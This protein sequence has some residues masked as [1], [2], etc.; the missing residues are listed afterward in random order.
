MTGLSLAGVT[1]LVS[2][3]IV[4]GA[5]C[6]SSSGDNGSQTSC[7]QGTR[8]VGQ[9]CVVAFDASATG[10]GSVDGAP[11]SDG[12]PDANADASG[13]AF[14]GVAAV[15]PASTTS[16]FAA[17][18][19]VQNPGTPAYA[20]RYLVFASPAGT[21]IDYTK[22]LA[23]TAPGATS[24]TISKLGAGTVSVAVRALDAAGRSDRNTVV[25]S[26]S[27]AADTTAP[28]FAGATS[29]APAGA[30]AVT[31]AWKAA[32]D[33]LTP[34]AALVYDVYV[35]DPSGEYDFAL[36]ALTTA[37]GVTSATVT[38]LYDPTE[39]YRFIVRARDA[40]GNIDTNTATVTSTAGVDTTPPVFAGCRSAIADSAGSAIVTWNLAVD[41][42]TPQSLIAYDVY[43][44][45]TEGT[46]DFTKP[47]STVT[48]LGAA[49][50][51][52]LT[53]GTTWYFVCR[54]RD[55]SHNEDGNLVELSTLTLADNQPPTFAGLTGAQVDG[56]ARTV[57]FT[58]NPGSNPVTPQDLLVY[59]V[60][61]AQSPGGE[62]FAGPP[63]ASSSPGATGLLVTDLTPDS[64]L[65]WV[66]RV[67]DQAGNHDSNVVEASGTILVSF[68]RQVQVTFS[69]YC[70]V[71]GCH[72]PGNPTGSLVLAPG[73]AYSYLVNV[74]SLEFPSEQRVLPG[75]S[76]DSYLFRKVTEN[77][78]PVGWQMPAPATGSVLT[79]EEKQ[80]IGD[81]ITQGAVN[82]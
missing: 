42:A 26:V 47:A 25:K 53:F 30:G 28:T 9:T 19:G 79:A 10:E 56:L 17:W 35:S 77:P 44:S 41:D 63:L 52:G 4:S 6:S 12:A 55:Y 11:Q 20:M 21:A 8:L 72:V 1:A 57:Q 16:V 32:S 80:T 81:W 33:D 31:L 15:A 59:D 24:Y 64:T 68:E 49:E 54:A 18:T 36:P 27:P 14:A 46:F 66:V 61:Q 38:Y 50:V 43:A 60:Y 73:F 78:P 48:G 82:N 76:A 45:K 40:A 5:A 67:R 34:A 3:A 37:P 2:I 74:Q 58:W 71:T 70:A 65:Y 62:D 7:G 75:D 51:Q 22:P 39:T 69:S 13:P 29:A 23:T